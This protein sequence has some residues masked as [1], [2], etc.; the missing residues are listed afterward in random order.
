MTMILAI[1]SAEATKKEQIAKLHE[2][3]GRS[4]TFNAPELPLAGYRG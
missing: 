4:L 1:L 2:Y 3:Y